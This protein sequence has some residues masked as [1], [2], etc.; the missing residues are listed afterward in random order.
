MSEYFDAGAPA[1]VVDVVQKWEQ[2][3][4]IHDISAARSLGPVD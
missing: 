3:A 1:Y 2:G 4:A